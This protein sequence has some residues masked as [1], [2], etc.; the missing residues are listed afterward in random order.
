MNSKIFY[1]LIISILSTTNIWS[2]IDSKTTDA[3]IGSI[4]KPRDDWEKRNFGYKFF[5]VRN[6]RGK[7]AVYKEG[8]GALN[9]MKGHTEYDAVANKLFK[10]IGVEEMEPHP[11]I[12]RRFIYEIEDVAG[13]IGNLLYVGFGESPISFEFTLEEYES[14]DKEDYGCYSYKVDEDKFSKSITTD[15]NIFPVG[16][17]LRI[18]EN[19]GQKDAYMTV[20]VYGET[21]NVGEKGV[22]LLLANGELYEL[23]EEEVDSQVNE[24]NDKSDWI[25]TSF[26]RLTPE[27]TEI[28][29]KQPIVAVKLYIY[30]DD[31]TALES[32]KFISDINCLIN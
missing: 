4:L 15:T 24:L 11:I 9:M 22:S 12:G 3:L 25:Y 7:L 18:I 14:R 30:E 26:F 28:L 6:K 16:L 19:K 8:K 29:Y 20:G 10:I 2:Q 31:L 32:L 17:G 23:P 5:R 13:E 1:L 21:L 27:L